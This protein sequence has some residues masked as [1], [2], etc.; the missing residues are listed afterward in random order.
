MADGRSGR[1][2][3]PAV[4]LALIFGAGCADRVVGDDVVAGGGADAGAPADSDSASAGGSDDGPPDTPWGEAPPPLLIEQL[5]PDG[6]D[7]L[8]VVDNSG[9]MGEE[10]GKLS[11]ALEEL[12]STLVAV[13]GLDFRIAFTTT[14]NGNP[15]CTTADTGRLKLSSCRTRLD[16]FVATSPDGVLDASAEGCLDVCGLDEVT[17]HNPWLERIDGVGNVEDLAAAIAC[18]APQGITGCGYEQPL[19][20]MRKALLR[21]SVAGDPSEGFVRADAALAVVVLTDEADCSHNPA[22]ESVFYEP[23]SFWH[24]D[25]TPPSSLCWDAG[26]VCTGG[27]DQAWDECHPANKTLA[28]A[29][30]SDATDAV[31]HPVQRYVDALMAID[32][33]KQ[34]YLV[35]PSVGMVLVAGVPEDFQAGGVPVSYPRTG[36]DDFVDLFGVGP[37]CT[38]ASGQA[39][40]PVRLHEV[41]NAFPGRVGANVSSVCEVGYDP[42]LAPIVALASAPVAPRCYPQCAADVDPS[43]P[44]L[45]VECTVTQQRGTPSGRVTETIPRCDGA[46][47]QLPAGASACWFA[48][49][50]NDAAQCD[51]GLEFGMLRAE[52]A[53]GGT[54]VYASCTP[55]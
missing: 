52:P 53:P 37:G 1:I 33:A 49:T 42:A 30:A 55:C 14:D 2:A 35:E 16:D 38:T 13:E 24:G 54:A 28:G 27:D 5:P 17:A 15:W 41:A 34:P 10:Q 22:A 31:L 9:S 43:Q 32:Q 8:V 19:E 7:I 25:G 46:L 39:A 48:Q 47:A 3:R 4:A 18:A 26:V 23:S 11:R 21:T 40:P 45:Q 12:A 50:E 36:P 44:G 20:S 29:P 51:G 6:V